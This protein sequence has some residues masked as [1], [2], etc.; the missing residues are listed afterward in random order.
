MILIDSSL[1]ISWL[2]QRENPAL[3]LRAWVG[4]RDL[5]VCGVVRAEV[6]RGVRDPASR[7]DLAEFFDL[8]VDIPTT[9]ETWR[10]V[11][12]LAWELDRHGKVLPLT[13]L[14]IA[15]CALSVGADVI[16]S[17]GHFAQIP[18]LNT[19]PQP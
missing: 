10:R 19:R 12:D 7:N 2:R 6:L 14:I 5:A 18:G 3:H 11:A 13:D 17:D 8:L 16:S 4:Q 1:Y 15:A 9:A